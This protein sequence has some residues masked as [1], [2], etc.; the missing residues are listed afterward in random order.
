MR[1]WG[2]WPWCHRTEVIIICIRHD[3]LVPK[4]KCLYKHLEIICVHLGLLFVDLRSSSCSALALCCLV[5]ITLL[6]T[7]TA[8]PYGIHH[9]LKQSVNQRQ[10]HYLWWE[11][12]S[13]LIRSKIKCSSVSLGEIW[14]ERLEN[15]LPAQHMVSLHVAGGICGF[16]SPLSF[17][18]LICLRHHS[19]GAGRHSLHQA[20]VNIS[21]VSAWICISPSLATTCGHTHAHTHI[22]CA[23]LDTQTWP[24]PTCS[25]VDNQNQFHP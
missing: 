22:T 10:P 9:H 5:I 20:W 18:P 6:S 4:P 19:L 17:P 15:H 23:Q 7:V 1:L 21:Q 8:H 12:N 11:L 16:L 3:A 13:L 25:Y 24:P 14:G 2:Y